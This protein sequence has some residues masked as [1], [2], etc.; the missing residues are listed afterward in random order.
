MCIYILYIYAY[1]YILPTPAFKIFA[2][3]S[4][5]EVCCSPLDTAEALL[6][7][8]PYKSCEGLR[9]G[10]RFHGLGFGHG[11]GL[12]FSVLGCRV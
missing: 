6:A 9:L 4:T 2:P 10:V 1:I 8:T 11:L 3:R 7:P 5:V 12:G